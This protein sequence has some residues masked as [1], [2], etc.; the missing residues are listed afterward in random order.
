M[1]KYIYILTLSIA[2]AFAACSDD[3]DEIFDKSATERLNERLTQTDEVLVSSEYGWAFDYYPGEELEY[4]GIIYTIKFDGLNATVRTE[5]APG[6][7]ET[8]FY[9]L[10]ND[11][12]AVLS[13]D[14]YNSL[15]HY[16]A[17]PSA[18][19]YQ[20]LHGD[21]EFLIDSVGTDIVLLHGKRN[22]N[23]ALLRRLT[24]PADQYYVKIDSISQLFYFDRITSNGT[25]VDAFFNI[26]D[27]YYYRDA[28][29]EEGVPFVP[30][31]R[32]LRFYKPVT[33]NGQRVSEFVYDEKELTLTDIYTD[34]QW[35]AVLDNSFLIKQLGVSEN[36]L[37]VSFDN[38]GGTK[39]FE[40]DH[41]DQINFSSDYDWIQIQ[42]TTNKN[43]SGK[44]VIDVTKNETGHIRIGYI[45]AR[46]LNE[47]HLI[48]VLQYTE[49]TDI[50]GTY[51]MQ[52][53]DSDDNEAEAEVAIH[54]DRKG[55]FTLDMGD[56]IIPLEFDREAFAF[57]I[58]SH[59]SA[60]TVEGRN[61]TY[62]LGT[63]F[64]TDDYYWTS[65]YPDYYF[66]GD[67][68]VNE[69]GKLYIEF[70]QGEIYGLPIT[71]IFLGAYSN[72]KLTADSYLGWWDAIWHPVLIKE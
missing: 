9:S 39:N 53:I 7:E 59:V 40:F 33:I 68:E 21:F 66:A 35:H 49:A 5:I 12:G 22:G 47:D 8:S 51:K 71:G 13:F 2:A 10:K 72:S 1:R 18:S 44:V 26:D 6:E 60:G 48:R 29:D 62:Y 4:S 25:D 34:K 46:I 32:G 14:T 42:T 55:N 69:D 45:K 41:I 54:R 36:I 57:S 30:T 63:I 23:R 70:N 67:I 38:K 65:H 56:Y 24:L 17:T 11:N 20:A 37:V 43:T 15:L 58:A 27:R 61:G 16:F 50:P 19:E 28:D 31:D 3:D 52:Y 64:I